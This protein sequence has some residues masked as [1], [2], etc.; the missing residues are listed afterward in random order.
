M[1]YKGR[2]IN[3]VIVQPTDLPVG[4][5]DPSGATRVC[6]SDGS[7]RVGTY[8]PNGAL[9]V[10]ADVGSLYEHPV[11]APDG[12]IYVTVGGNGFY[13]PSGAVNIST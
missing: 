3:I 5:Y 11:Y 13:M 6:V 12:S 10:S 8:A 4:L 1:K 9:W 7:K 2:A